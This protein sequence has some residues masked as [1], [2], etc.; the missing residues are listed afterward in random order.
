M[1]CE[2]H[3][4][5]LFCKTFV[6]ERTLLRKWKDNLKNG[7]KYLQM[8]YLIWIY[9]SEYILKTL[10]TQQPKDKAVVS[11]YTAHLPIHTESPHRPPPALW[12]KEGREQWRLAKWLAVRDKG[13]LHTRLH[14]SGVAGTYTGSTSDLYLHMGPPCFGTS[15]LRGKSPGVGRE[16]NTHLK[17]T[18]PAWVQPSGVLLQ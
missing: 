17:G 9:Y 6:H 3:L 1:L 18:E 16:K 10:T 2:F 11:L 5:K 8:I 15:L 12:S 4:N 14:L 13:H 7:R